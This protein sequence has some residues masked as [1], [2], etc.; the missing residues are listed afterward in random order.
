MNI[1]GYSKPAVLV[2]P[3]PIDAA[4]SAAVDAGKYVAILQQYP[5]WWQFQCEDSE[6]LSR[7]PLGISEW[8]ETL[9]DDIKVAYE[10]YKQ[11]QR[12][13]NERPG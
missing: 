9:P 6:M 4:H 5:H 3:A 1:T 12:N 2:T 8:F 13:E 7:L 10:Q 11:K